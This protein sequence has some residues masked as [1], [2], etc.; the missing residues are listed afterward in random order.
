MH[1]RGI[2]SRPIEEEMKE[3]YL[4]Y[5]MSVIISRALPDVRD[6][7]KPVHR[8]ILFAMHEMGMGHD[9][10]YK[11][12]ARIVGEVLGKYHPHG[13]QAVYDALVRMVQPFS[14]RY[15]LIDGQGNFG[16]VDGDSAAAMRYTEARLAK[17][18][19]E[20]LADIDKDTVDF[21][22]NFDASLKEPTVLPGKFP[23]LLVNGA[24]GIAV[25]MATNI[26]PHNLSEVV[27]GIIKVI[28][29]PKI[30][31]KELMETIKG[32]DFPTGGIIIKNGAMLGIYHTG[33]GKIIVRG[34]AELDE[35]KHRIIVTEIPYMVNKAELIEHIAELVKNKVIDGITGL[36]DES[37]KEGMRIVIE[38]RKDIPLELILN[39]LYKH[40]R[41]QETFGVI[42]L[43][44]VDNQPRVLGIKGLIEEY[45]KHRKEVITRRTRFELNKAEHRAHILEGLMTA[46]DHIDEIV[47]LIKASKSVDEARTGLMERFELTEIQAQA[48]LDM[49]LQ[50]LTN[51]ERIKIKNEYEELQKLIAELRAVLASEEKILGII[52]E[53]LKEIKKRY[54]DERRSEIVEIESEVEIE[55][56]DLIKKEEVVILLTQNNYIKRLPLSVYKAQRRGGKGII[57]TRTKEE[58]IVKDVFVAN[59]HDILLFFTNMGKVYMLKA[60]KVPDV[61]RYGR[62]KALVNLLNLNEGE[63]VVSLIPIKGFSDGKYVVMITKNGTIKKTALQ[64]FKNIRGNG[65]IAIKL[66]K[67]ELVNVIL[68]SGKEE[69]VIATKKGRAIRFK[70]KDVRAMG[71]N[72][73]GVRGIRLAQDDKVV[74]SAVVDEN[75]S[76]LT[77]TEKGYGKRS[78]YELY[79]ITRRG[80]KGIINMKIREK[81]GDVV[82]ISNVREEDDII[83]VSKNGIAIRVPASQ[84][85]IMG[86]ATQG[87]RV[88]RLGEG[89]KVA[90][91]VRAGGK[92]A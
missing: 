60:Y 11:K 45:I 52:K 92:H 41:L 13:D 55:E 74:G 44:L 22:P 64:N 84:I 87:V 58:D 24:S 27:D 82:G 43:V 33:R 85:P 6:G 26:P 86:R 91:F 37:S 88:M 49:R 8:R 83:I 78:R 57:G 63:K 90:S 16:S 50:K 4:D 53:E 15:P 77:I 1:K 40:T 70:E 72:A 20:M 75:G 65:I 42:M 36:R 9:K 5:A 66:N 51:L 39:Q 7:L 89:D 28:E 18:A 19:E 35:E 29:N 71:R 32:P 67:D 80:G 46:L 14:L 23:N 10:P 56:E 69:I 31:T 2:I 79:R 38:V 68:T 25:G 48:I 73:A 76:L 17:T 21:M 81:N 54:G 30:D 3:S 61:G 62:G 34:K 59:T 12:C 47:A